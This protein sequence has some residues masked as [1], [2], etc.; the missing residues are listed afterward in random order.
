MPRLVLRIECC[1]ITSRVGL[2]KLHLT[3]L[4][5]VILKTRPAQ[6]NTIRNCSDDRMV[7]WGE[8]AT[9]ED[10]HFQHQQHQQASTQS[11]DVACKG[12]ARRPLPP[13]TEGRAA[14]ISGGCS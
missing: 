2:M 7:F 10:R 9:F 11:N 12:A 6:R 13:G 5:S 14:S 8:A 1:A 4:P 3:A